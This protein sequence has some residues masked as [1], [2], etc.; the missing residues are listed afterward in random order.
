MKEISTYYGPIFLIHGLT[1]QASKVLELFVTLHIEYLVI[2]FILINWSWFNFM[3]LPSLYHTFGIY[4]HTYFPHFFWCKLEKLSS[5]FGVWHTFTSFTLFFIFWRLLVI[6]ASYASRTNEGWQ[7][8]VLRRI[9]IVLHP[10]GRSLQFPH[11]RQW[12]IR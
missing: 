3:F 10:S 12:L 8:W 2:E 7:G 6:E 11:G 5:S 1:S 4:S 9:I